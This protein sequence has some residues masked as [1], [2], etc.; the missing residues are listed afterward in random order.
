M[1]SPV[2]RPSQT[3]RSTHT[4]TYAGER[5]ARGERAADPGRSEAA[6]GPRRP[7]E[8]VPPPAPLALCVP[9]GGRGAWGGMR[10]TPHRFP[11]LRLLPYLGERV[12]GCPRPGGQG[13]GRPQGEIWGDVGR[14]GEIWGD[15]D[16]EADGLKAR[17]RLH[18]LPR[19]PT[20]RR[21]DSLATPLNRLRRASLQR[22]PPRRPPVKR[23]RSFV[24]RSP[25]GRGA[26]PR[27]RLRGRRLLQRW[28][29]RRRSCGRAVP[30]ARRAPPRSRVLTPRWR[31]LLRRGPGEDEA[32]SL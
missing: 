17:E 22:V 31:V 24:Q 14:C 15:V 29:R 4:R 1:H 25:R 5:H 30:R 16:K 18:P 26:A 7:G 11:P 23:R 21:S 13:G 32:R 9:P 28:R 3:R 8:R 10:G 2:T 12:R 20:K 27:S 19:Q 6:H